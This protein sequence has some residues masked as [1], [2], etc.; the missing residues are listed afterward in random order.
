MG[1]LPK[2]SL[3]N[4]FVSFL[5]VAENINR[6]MPPIHGK[7]ASDVMLYFSKSVQMENK[8]LILDGLKISTFL[9][10][11]YLSNKNIMWDRTWFY[12]SAVDW[13]VKCE[14]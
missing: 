14:C 3:L 1:S 5:F 6:L 2:S 13:I 10:N 4:G 7:W 11:L 9:A 8:K 12:P